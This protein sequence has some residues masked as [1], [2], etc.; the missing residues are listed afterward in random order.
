V[1][2]GLDTIDSFVSEYKKNVFQTAENINL[3]D[4]SHLFIM[5]G[6]GRLV[7]CSTG[8]D[9]DVMASVW[10]PA[11]KKI[12]TDSA[13]GS[14]SEYAGRAEE[15]GAEK[16]YVARQFAPWDWVIF[17]AMEDQLV[18]G[19]ERQ[20]RNAT[21][22]IAGICSI[23][24]IAMILIIFN[25]FFATPVRIIISSASAIAKGRHVK[26]IDVSSHDELGDLARNMETMSHA[27]QQHQAEIKKSHDQL[28]T[29]VKERTMELETALSKIKT[30]TGLL[31]I[32]MHCKKIRDDKGY[33]KQM[34]AIALR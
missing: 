18:R 7:F 1:K 30:L 3:P 25:K 29:R 12:R 14:A 27:I 2:N 22:G 33:W 17:F 21:I 6:T 28:E 23:L 26:Q 10:G 15:A 16:L 11:A 9:P 8:T 32:C 24:S 31:P 34:E 5:D 13:G 20:I 19:A 4:R